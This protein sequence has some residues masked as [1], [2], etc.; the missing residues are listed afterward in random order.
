MILEP[1]KIK[2][3]TVSN[4][5]SC[6]CNEV[7][8]LDAM[9]VECLLV[10]SFLNV[11]FKLVLPSPLLIERLFSSS[12]H[13]AIRVVSYSCFWMLILLPAILSPAWDLSRPVYWMMYPSY[14]FNTRVTMYA[15]SFPFPNFKSFSCSMFDS[16]GRFLTYIQTC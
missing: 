3:A 2:S 8:G 5:P 15:L 6:I 9:N 13:C 16:K 10:N 14:K 12:L 7:V 4:F 1:K 11:E